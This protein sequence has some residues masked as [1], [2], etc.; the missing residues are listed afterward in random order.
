MWTPEQYLAEIPFLARFKM[1][2]LMS[3]YLSWFDVENHPD[4]H[5]GEANRW[6]EE[7]P[8]WKREGFEEVVRQCRSHA[9]EFCFGMSPSACCRR[10][11]SSNPQ[12]SVNL[13]WRHF[14]WAQRLGVRWFS[15][16]V[17]DGLEA[18][19]QV[20]L[21]NA[22]YRRL[23]ANDSGAQ[24]VFSPTLYWGD[25]TGK[26]QQPYLETLARELDPEIYLFWTG[27]AVVGRFT[28]RSA[29]SFQRISG[30]RI[31]LWDN[32]PVNDDS[33]AMH[34]GP[35]FGREPDLC[36]VVE[37]YMSNPHCK[38]NEINRIPLAT[39]ADYA[40]NPCSYDP[41][42][43]IGQAILHLAQTAPQ[44]ELLRDLVETYPGMLIYG[45]AETDL[46]CAREQY[47]RIASAPHARQGTLAF[48]A[49]MRDLSRRLGE[50]FPNQYKAEKKTLK[51]DVRFLERQ[52]QKKYRSPSTPLI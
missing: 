51:D 14:K 52:F 26:V 3:C 43:S 2:F 35:V 48:I 20:K 44:R 13:L 29:E 47:A 30:H 9:I 31:F 34:L 46:N 39:C 45:R 12:E 15:L 50:L 38:Q 27:D 5:D 25:G 17:T 49:H 42:R 10:S 11:V 6:W 18:G 36:E 1:N 16:D 41:K 4:W 40:W 7:L 22:I 37:G 23:R 19:G 33:P 32:Y 24:M 21:V 28:R 8:A